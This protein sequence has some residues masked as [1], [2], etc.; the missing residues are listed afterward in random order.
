MS[1]DRFTP[2]VV[3]TPSAVNFPLVSRRVLE[4][5]LRVWALQNSA[6]PA[7]TIV[8]VIDAGTSADPADRPG[9][10]SLVAGLV[11]EGAGPYDAIELSDALARIGGQLLTEV[12]T[13][14]TSVTLTVLAKHFN[15]G[16]KLMADV[17]RRPRMAA[18]DFDRVRDLRLGR[19][20]QVSRTPAAAADRALLTAVYGNH[21]YAHGSLG[22]TRATER[23]TLDEVRDWWSVR[24]RPVSGAVLLAGDLPP[25]VAHG[26]IDA[27]FGDWPSGVFDPPPLA[28][29]DQT[30]ATAVRI[31]HRPGAPQSEIRVG[32]LGPSRS[33]P[34]YYALIGLNAMLGGQFTSRINRNLRE[35]RA[36]TYGARTGFD[37]RRAGGLFSCDSSVQADAT[38]VA[39]SEVVREMRDIRVDGA[40]AFDELDR[41]RASLTRGYVRYFETA[42]QLARAMADLA[43]HRLPDDTFDRFVPELERLTVNDITTAARTALRPDDAALIVVGDMDVVGK[44]KDRLGRPVEQASVEF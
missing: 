19:L 28:P 44:D 13:D 16:L 27:A 17:V 39:L 21:P 12:G 24:W 40:V 41:A 25:E 2:P 6:V 37:M 3:G 14:V 18:P 22:T 43:V 26:A 32:H 23:A 8:A 9:L 10:A 1:L 4:N 20:K 15:T 30:P 33:T 42:A 5:G 36:I 29:P 34:D 38:A 7:V 11:T 31:V 35:T